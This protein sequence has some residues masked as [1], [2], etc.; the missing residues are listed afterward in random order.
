MPQKHYKKDFSVD[1][2]G[3]SMDELSSIYSI[4]LTKRREISVVGST[5]IRLRMKSA[6][7]S[8]MIKLSICYIFTFLASLCLNCQ[9]FKDDYWVVVNLG[10][11]INHRNLAFSCVL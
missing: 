2:C 10:D 3:I 8:L 4:A 5:R 1:A 6:M 9:Y 11:F 7:L